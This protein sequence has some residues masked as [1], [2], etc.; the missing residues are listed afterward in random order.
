MRH[1]YFASILVQDAAFF[2]NIGPGEISMRASKDV[3]AIRTA[4]GEK[5]GHLLWTLSTIVAVSLQNTAC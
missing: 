1:A 4:F 2:D 3:E 5:L